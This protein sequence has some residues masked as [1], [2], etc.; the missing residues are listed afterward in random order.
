MKITLYNAKVISNLSDLSAQDIIGTGV[1]TMGE[2]IKSENRTLNLALIN[3]NNLTGNALLKAKK[4]DAKSSLE[5]LRFNIRCTSC[6]ESALIFYTLFASG[7][8][9]PILIYQSEAISRNEESID[10][11]TINIIE[12]NLFTDDKYKS[13]QIELYMDPSE[14][15]HKPLDKKL[16]TFDDLRINFKWNSSI[17]LIEFLNLQVEKT[18]S[19]MDY[20]FDGLEINLSIAIDFTSSNGVLKMPSSLHY[21]NSDTNQY[22]E[23]IR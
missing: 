7:N 13:L 17:G 15:T 19:F 9:P 21:I 22:M 10:W 18:P 4:V 20:L 3:E 16:F 5:L 11:R 2:F 23:T 14:Q 8:Q 12:P 6:K 1:F